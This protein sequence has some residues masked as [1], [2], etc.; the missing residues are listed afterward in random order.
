[1]NPLTAAFRNDRLY[2]TT[3]DALGV[4]DNVRLVRVWT[5]AFPALFADAPHK[6]LDKDFGPFDTTEDV[7]VGQAGWGGVGGNK[8]DTAAVVFAR[9]ST[10]FYNEVRYSAHFGDE[11]DMR[12]SRLLKAGEFPYAD[13]VTNK[14]GD[15]DLN[16]PQAWGDTAGAAVDPKDDTGIWLAQQYASKIPQLPDYSIWVS[17]V[18]G[19]VYF[20]YL[21]TDGR[22][23]PS[24]Q[25]GGGLTVFGVL[26]NGGD[27]DAP[28]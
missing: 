4:F 23:S 1:T 13:G 28:A 19:P 22:V 26:H 6:F 17:K 14:A 8:D 7:P 9:I 16:K 21:F 24:T 27:G 25:I 5:G 15:K 3:N 2:I 20:D 12:L 18:L 10:A 11:P